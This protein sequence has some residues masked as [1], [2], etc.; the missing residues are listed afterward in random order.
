MDSKLK[1]IALWAG[2]GASV[3]VSSI[4]IYLMLR[5]EEEY[6]VKR[7]KTETTKHS[8]VKVTVPK[9]IVGGVI[10]RQGG[11]I[12]KIQDKTKTKISFDDHDLTEECDRVAVIRGAPGDVEEAEELL[13]ACIVEQSNIVTETVFVP[14][15]ACGRI[16]GR[17]GESVRHMCRITSAKILVDRSGGDD[18]ER[19]NLKA[20]TITGTREQIR[21]AVSLIDEK[22]AEEEAFQQKMALASSAGRAALYRSRPLAIKNAQLPLKDDE[23]EP[24]Y[25]QEELVATSADGYVEIFISSLENPGRFWVQLVG[26][27][28]TTLDKLVSDMTGY[29]SHPPNQEANALTS[30]SIGD[31]VAS[32]FDQ[33]EC[34][35]RSRVI[36]IQESDY[37]AAETM[38]QVHYLDF[39][40][41]G[42]YKVKELCAL[43]DE[44]RYLPL[45]AIECSLAGV[46]PR[47]GTQWTDEAVDTFETLTHA[48]QWKVVMAKV[49]SKAK[50]EDGFPGYKYAVELVDTNNKQDVNVA[51]EMIAQNLA[52]QAI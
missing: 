39:G 30:V 49:V 38:V 50:R 23:K 13:K 5:Q 3:T 11:N 14:G 15:K 21:M 27:Q 29:Y 7:R 31:L 16:I 37:S 6:E 19:N 48:S 10:G 9:D 17:N 35:Y 4:L 12:K 47:D 45:Q 8:I 33:D 41:K 18:R 44:Y 25:I 22:L 43:R 24:D 28:S 1:T 42:E 46:Q 51:T 20:I 52:V 26:A 32:P 40:E 34:W 2:V 36:T